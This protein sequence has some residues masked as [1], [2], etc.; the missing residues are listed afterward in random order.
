MRSLTKV[1]ISDFLSLFA[2]E[3]RETPGNSKTERDALRM[4]VEV[5]FAAL[6]AYPYEIVQAAVANVMRTLPFRPK[7][8]DICNEIKRFQTVNEPTGEEVWAEISATLAKVR[9][10]AAG[11]WLT[12]TREDGMTQGKWCMISN[13]RM[14]AKLSEAARLYVRSV[15]D[16]VTIAYKDEKE[17]AIE[18]AIFLKRFDGIREQERLR[19]ETP[20]E[21]LELAAKNGRQVYPL[22]DADGRVSSVTYAE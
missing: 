17:R 21:I 18:K 5:W 20:K 8:A 2:V 3:Y 14:Y 6:S 4:R 16:L 1:D 10:N 13:E 9:W 15:G 12:A 7:L 22:F 11:Y 19:K